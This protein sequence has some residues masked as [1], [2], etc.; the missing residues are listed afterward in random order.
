MENKNLD[1]DLGIIGAGPAGLSA[2]I[3]AAR[4]GLSVV[5]FEREVHG[6]QIVSS[7]EV[8]NY[9]ALGKVSGADFANALY[10]QAVGFGA[11]ILYDEVTAA[12]LQG[13]VKLLHTAEKTYRVRAVVVA[14]GVA[15]RK[16]DCPGEDRLL[17][18]GVSYCATCDGAFFAGKTVAVVGGGNTA[19]EDALYLA[20]RCEKVYLIHRRQGFRASEAELA[21]LRS[22]PKVEFLLDAQV[23]EIRGDMQVESIL[24][25]STVGAPDREIPVSA[26]FVA[27]GLIPSNELVRGQLPMTEQGY[28]VAD[29]SC[30]TAL[31]RVYAAGDTREKA[32]RQLVTAAADG[33]LAGS[34]AVADLA[35][36]ATL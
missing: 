33:A 24:L 1:Y 18:R 17:G 11:E 2:A 22:N 14:G 29:D 10:E 6:G 30:R 15:R 26:V 23:A 34:S 31:A 3:Y 25:H 21:K 36:E 16:L 4:G 20:A 32:L 9:P 35:G 19:V 5:C 28:L 8:E 27:V 12:E 7:P 13:E